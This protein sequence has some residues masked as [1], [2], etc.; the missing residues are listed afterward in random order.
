MNLL[1]IPALFHPVAMVELERAVYEVSEDVGVVEVCA[2]VSSTSIEC[3][4]TVPFEVILSTSDS[5][6]GMYIF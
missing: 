2:V 3:S 6:A 5:S 1:T 4:V